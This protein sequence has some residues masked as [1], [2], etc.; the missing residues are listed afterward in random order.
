M[1]SCW[2]RVGVE[3]WFDEFWVRDSKSEERSDERSW[4]RVGGGIRGDEGGGGSEDH[5]G[6]EKEEEVVTRRRWWEEGSWREEGGGKGVEL[7]GKGEGELELIQTCWK[8]CNETHL[9]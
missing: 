6:G 1:L 8:R 5:R 4:G 7:E 2:G 3:G 9:D